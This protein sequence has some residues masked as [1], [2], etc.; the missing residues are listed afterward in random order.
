MRGGEQPGSTL[1]S[2][3]AHVFGDIDQERAPLEGAIWSNLFTE[4]GNWLSELAER[5]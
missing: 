4:L 5:K 3:V 2:Q 1:V